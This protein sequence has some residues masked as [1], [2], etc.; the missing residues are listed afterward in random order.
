MIILYSDERRVNE[1]ERRWHLAKLYV[2]HNL[3]KTWMA[4]GREKA[5]ITHVITIAMKYE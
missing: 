3:Y 1:L 5:I 2:A 4:S